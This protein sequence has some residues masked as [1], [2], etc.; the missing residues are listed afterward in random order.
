V[1]VPQLEECPHCHQPK[2]AHH[3]CPTCGWYKGR[4]AVH[5]KQRTTTEA[6]S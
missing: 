1:S 4:E 6:G 2:Q 3:A 5:I